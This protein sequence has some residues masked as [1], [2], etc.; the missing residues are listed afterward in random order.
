MSPQIARLYAHVVPVFW[1]YLWLQ[2]R[3][4]FKRQDVELRTLLISVTRWGHVHIVQ[5]GDHWRA[6][7]KPAAVKPSWD[8][9]VWESHIAPN[10]AGVFLD[11]PQT[12]PPRGD[13][14]PRARGRCPAGAEGGAPHPDTS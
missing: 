12:S 14:L 9:P 6:Y 4:I 1:P 3:W 2:L 7:R 11:E 13:L 5:V 10:L 8:D